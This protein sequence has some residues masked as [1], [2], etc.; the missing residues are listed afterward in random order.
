LEESIKRSAK[1]RVTEA[2]SASKQQPPQ[3]LQQPQPQKM[4]PEGNVDAS[5]ASKQQPP[6]Q[7]QQS[8]PQKMVPEGNVDAIKK[9]PFRQKESLPSLPPAVRYGALYNSF[10][11]T[12]RPFSDNGHSSNFLYKAF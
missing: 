10:R 5:N 2:S 3:Q 12:N 7:L 11:H 8:Q 9:K 6:Q 4:V 1:D